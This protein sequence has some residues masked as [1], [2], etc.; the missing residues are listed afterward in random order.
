MRKFSD[1]INDADYPVNP[2]VAGKRKMCPFYCILGNLK[3]RC[4]AGSSFQKRH[5]SYEGVDIC[6]EWLL[7]SNFREWMET[8]PW[9]NMDL[10]KDILVKGNKIYSPDTC[11]FIPKQ[12]NKIL[13]LPPKKGGDLPKGVHFMKTSNGIPNKSQ[14]PFIAQIN[15]FSEENRHL[16]MF[17]DPLEAH[18]AWQRAKID[19]ILEAISWWR[20]DD[21]VK[22]SVQEDVVLA[23]L[24]RVAKIQQDIDQNIETFDF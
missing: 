7:F 5:K 18:K 21:T 23:L 16:G 11:R 17:S 4:T 15:K 20:K 1:F 10:D 6:D 19:Q 14:K 13:I 12:L 2:V 22:H 24:S 9:K 3:N 8:Q